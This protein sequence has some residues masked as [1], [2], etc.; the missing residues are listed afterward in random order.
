MAVNLDE[1][2][3]L[4]E[5]YAE[6]EIA[7]NSIPQDKNSEHDDL[8]AA[9]EEYARNEKS[10]QTAIQSFDGLDDA[11]RNAK[12]LE[13]STEFGVPLDTINNDIEY[14]EKTKKLRETQSLLGVSP[15]LKHH[16]LDP[17]FISVA[18]DDLEELSLLEK[19]AKVVTTGLRSAPHAS[20]SSA[21]GIFAQGAQLFSDYIETPLNELF[22]I[23]GNTS[24]GL[25]E[26][27]LADSK[28]SGD[29]SGS[30]IAE[31]DSI[32][33]Q[34]AAQGIQSFGTQLP[35]I[36]GSILTGSPSV[37]LAGA[38]VQS[39]GASSAKALQEGK[40][41]V[42]SLTFG[43][44]DAGI[45]VATEFLPAIK[46][47]SDIKVGSSLF[48]TLANQVAAEI[49]GEQVAT[50]LQDL[51]EY[52][53]LNPDKP[54]SS[55]LEERPGAAY[56]TLIATLV[57]TGAQTTVAHST[58]K[59]LDRFGTE[60]NRVNASQVRLDN[61]DELI[62]AANGTKTAGRSPETLN[63]F[64]QDTLGADDYVSLPSTD[65]QA[66]LNN[67]EALAKKLQEKNPELY[68][69]ITE[70]VIGE[71]P[72]SL[73]EYVTYFGQHHETLKQNLRGDLDGL[74][75][76][77]INEASS[78]ESF[79]ASASR[80][81]DEINNKS[82]IDESANKVKDQIFEQLVSTGRLSKEVAR[83]NAELHKSFAIAVGES[84]G[85]TP[86]QVYERYKLEVK[87][88]KESNDN[89][90]YQAKESGFEGTDKGEALEYVRAREKGLDLS[91]EAR[92]ARAKEQG[93]DTDTVYY[94]GTDTDFSEF[95]PERAI[96]SQYWSTTDRSA[97]ESG[98]VGAAGKGVIKEFYARI[99][100]P[101]GWELYE[102]RGIG[103]LIALG[104][105]GVKLPE[106]GQTT[107]IAFN[108]SQYRS[109][110][111]AFDPDHTNSAKL[112]AQDARGQISLPDDL[113]QSPSVISLLENSDLSTFLHESGHF[114]FEVYRDIASRDDAPK[115]IKDD[116][117]A[118]LSHVGVESLSEWNNKSHEERREGHEKIARSFE[119]YLFEGKAPT[120]ELQTLF[121]RF[122]SWL[123]RVYESIKSLNV[124]LSQEVNQV[125]DRMLA[126]ERDIESQVQEPLF[127][128]EYNQSSEI[129]Q[130]EVNARRLSDLQWLDGAR[131]REL[132][133]AQKANNAK[134]REVVK[135]VTEEVQKEPI[136]QAIRFFRTGE[137][138][139]DGE[140]I[141]AN[142]GHRLSIKSLKEIYPPYE[143][144]DAP[145]WRSLGTGKYG[146]L[147]R[148]GLHPDA[149]AEIFGFTSGD[150]L[151]QTLLETP[152]LKDR[153]QEETDKRMLVRYGDIN[154]QEAL[155]EAVNAALS[156]KA[157]IKFVHSEYN[158]LAKR[159]GNKRIL[160]RDAK[161]YAIRHIS[162]KLVR[163]IRPNDYLIAERR[164]GRLAFSAFAKGDLDKAL[165]YKRDQVLNVHLYREARDAKEKSEKAVDHL[166]KYDSKGVRSK[167]EPDELD[168]IDK[169]LEAY[170]LRKSVTNKQLD[171]LK[172]LSEWAESVKE[173]G[174]DSI[175]DVSIVEKR[176][177]YKELTVEELIG[178][179][180][181]VQNIAHI[182]RNKKYLLAQEEKIELAKLA[183]LATESIVNHSN[184]KVKPRQT[185]D[186]VAG[187]ISEGVRQFVASHRKFSSIIRE[188]DGGKDN[189]VMYNAFIRDMNDAGDRETELNYQDGQALLEIFKPII[190]NV[191]KDRLP[192]NFDNVKRLIPGT[193]VSLATEQRLMFALNY[194]NEGNRQ[195]LI[196][197]GLDG[198]RAFT[199]AEV[200]GI[201]DSL[202]QKE[203]DFVQ[204]VFDYIG[205]K[206]EL[207]S[208]QER[209]L[210]GVT[211]KWVEPTPIETKY[212]TYP[213]G[214][215]PARYDTNLSTRSETLDA[216]AS[217]R[218]QM[219]GAF[220][221]STTRSSYAQQRADEVKG[222]PIL[223][224]FSVISA[225][226]N[227]VNHRLSWQEWIVNSQRLL[228]KL[229]KP[230]RDHYGPE[231]LR[232]LR[233]T[234]DD[235]ATNDF[236]IPTGMTR[237]FDHLRTGTTIVGMGWRMTTALIQPSGLAQSWAR[238]GGK[239][240]AQGLK[241]YWANP[242]K[243]SRLADEM[244]TGMKHRGITMNRE[245]NEILNKIRAGDT[246]STIRGSYFLMIQKMQRMVDVPTFWGAY[247][248]ALDQLE[249]QNASNQVERDKIDQQAINL[250]TQAVKDSQSSGVISDLARVQRGNS[251]WKLFTNFA[252]YFIATYN[253]NVENYRT[254]DFKNPASALNFLTNFA[255][256]NAIPAIF[257]VALRE[258]LQNECDGEYDCLA[259]KL[260]GEQ[261]SFMLAQN[262]VTREV[263]DA[264]RAAV[265]LE[266]FDYSGPPGLR[267]FADVVKLGKQIGQ[268]EA[269]EH[270][271]K[272]LNK[273]AGAVLHY[274]AGQLQA[275]VEGAIA[276]SEDEVD[277]VD[278]IKALIAGPPRED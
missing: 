65:L 102:K 8:F 73:A 45:E 187:N 184:R 151:I 97:I 7:L 10:Y 268:E 238:V 182:G 235:V 89:V 33:T 129:A 144:G 185:T 191:R 42:E 88:E 131:S 46:L 39:G 253:L 262:I 176:K 5:E 53:V 161:A 165:A 189:G 133:K 249:M 35:Y 229:D 217:L 163:D 261:I 146:L 23:E 255:I 24:A 120:A 18:H 14:Y 241:T 111:A 16:V 167:I 47:L 96:G 19:A 183:G 215:F 169:I 251:Y 266:S 15:I 180:D 138:E 154:S 40:S 69:T 212:G 216:G 179:K 91:Q 276:I 248:K 134:R 106:D 234:V 265:G 76:S 50:L 70:A 60:E 178:L 168:Q 112:L 100:N 244:S 72:V 159:T 219:Q 149:A 272:S 125:F 4:N 63:T 28:L 94:H 278:A 142:E 254:T 153:I 206:K 140:A 214:Y 2:R 109:I 135:E 103:E 56:Q 29:F 84:L 209:R 155:S 181:N 164:A 231:I 57:G 203:W 188:M 108:P 37:L 158:E 228:Q 224:N 27:W 99:D 221:K 236:Q 61:I 175:V 232:E 274:P 230:I 256:I 54:F 55:Y 257:S 233:N 30:I 101:A 199:E 172:S 270:L 34:A 83:A 122:R 9:N 223:L 48:K 17:Q 166:K 196:D 152:K 11:D 85:I 26:K 157:H 105:D 211:P 3:R 277:G 145:D 202:T 201:I 222:R 25:A 174:F 116:M 114:F 186:T 115:Q 247:Y 126:T 98:G 148:E 78:P 77:E 260:A 104:Y 124:E 267:P 81:V 141:K 107:L 36:L 121:Q 6:N 49:P 12:A 117:Q 118:L 171:E 239:W 210:T 208:E 95:D 177:H 62:N 192:L 21:S 160:A 79:D 143:I 44:T 227:E 226:L 195:R 237:F 119:A 173:N 198:N 240:M 86:E 1:I 31:N 218:E 147:A 259:E 41:S 59:L 275:T 38:G 220:F 75:L 68:D 194:G 273:V 246:S 269:D 110:H 193:D 58:A 13:Y 170:D 162:S 245:V 80:V 258:S 64:L 20:A 90:L 87:G 190:K 200:K 52:A 113:T 137:V 43:L 32:E 156:N 92:L 252:S 264:V 67:D 66:A 130:D 242:L 271:F 93:F 263:D 127:D 132:K 225:H 250:A 205:S 243:A 207:I 82:E 136:Y 74:T 71:V 213:G 22:G 197:G 51:N 150:H 139:Q 123:L 128:R 204:S